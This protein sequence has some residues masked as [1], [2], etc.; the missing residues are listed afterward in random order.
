MLTL[1]Q[2]DTN[3]GY[4]ASAQALSMDQRIAFVLPRFLRK[5]FRVFIRLFQG[6][7]KL[8]RHIGWVG[9][10]GFYGAVAAYGIYVGG[11]SHDVIKNTASASGFAIENIRVTGNTE[12]SE[13]DVLGPLGLDGST[14]LIGLDV[15]AARQR[16]LELPWVENA[17]IRKIYPNT[18]SVALNEREA[19]A[20]WQSDEGLSL[21]D[22]QGDEIV[23]YR[24]GRHAQLPLVV[25]RGA[26]T[27]GRDFIAQV[28]GYPLLA[29]KVRAYV[30][31]AD[32]RWDLLLDNGV[33][34]ML[35]ENDVAAAL[36]RIDKLDQ[37]EQLLSRDIASL[38]MRLDDRMTVRLTERG[39]Q[40]REQVLKERQKAMSRA[41]KRV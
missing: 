4:V 8:P 39:M 2:K 35:P 17:E 21:I 16:I 23:A 25:G 41:G 18:I 36:S 32:R 34:V 7:V 40:A 26:Q 9:A 11:H 15:E 37:S 31:V 5:P 38:D 13:I 33:R 6:R 10:L 30:R 27:E 3:G 20:I 12:T 29:S 1:G 19:Y 14:S 28:A 24:A 22:A